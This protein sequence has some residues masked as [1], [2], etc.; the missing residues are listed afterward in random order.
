MIAAELINHMVPPLKPTDD[1]HKAIVWMEELRCEYL[2]VVDKGQ[3]L[4]MI[5]EEIVLEANNIDLLI[6]ELVLTGTD[7]SVPLNTH[8]YDVVK[9][10]SD[11]K[12]SS[13][14]VLNDEGKYEGVITIQ[15]T[16]SAFAQS[17][18]VQ[19]SGAIIVLSMDQRDYSLAE[20]S[21]LIE[22]NQVKIVSSNVRNDEI[23]PNKI[24]LTL[25]INSLE[26]NRIVA[27]LERFGY[28]IIAR[29]KESPVSEKEKDHLDMLFRYLEI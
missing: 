7:C 12:I 27:T 9:K 16:V 21:R 2:P 23:D 14:A 19:T 11:L 10:S 26:I 28:K 15:D 13:V 18:A 22:E 3:F 24:K 5:S 25:K 1:A 20:I 6:K 29:F 17:E 8:F 4:G